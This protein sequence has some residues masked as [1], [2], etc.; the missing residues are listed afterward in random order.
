M[1][2]DGPGGQNLKEKKNFQGIVCALEKEKLAPHETCF[3]LE[4]GYRSLLLVQM[5]AKKFTFYK[6]KS[7]LWCF[8]ADNSSVE[9]NKFESDI[10][11]KIEF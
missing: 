2:L 9:Y 3:G 8:V 5:N 1:I 6:S 11:G 7:V 10:L 4:D